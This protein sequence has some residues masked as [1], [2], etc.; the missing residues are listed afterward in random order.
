VHRRREALVA[1]DD[2][3]EVE[4]QLAQRLDRLALARERRADHPLRVLE[5]AR[6]ELL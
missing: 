1:Q 5:L 3:L 4:G 6:L 2:W